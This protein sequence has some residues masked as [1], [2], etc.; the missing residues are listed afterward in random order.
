MKIYMMVDME[1]VSGICKNSQVDIG[2]TDYLAAR[3][4]M[5][6]D[7]NACIEGCFKGGAT[8]VVT[9]D[10]HGNGFNLIW[11]ELDPRAKYA[12][13][14]SGACRMPGLDGADGI[15]LLGYHAMAG[16]MHAV[17]EH[18]MSH[19][20]WQNFYING[21]RSGEI[22]I[23]AGIAGDS[24]VP[25]IMVSGDD[26]ACQE[27]QKLLPSVL[28]AQVKKGLSAEGAIL[29]SREESLKIIQDT[30]EK[31]VKGCRKIKPIKFKSPVKMRLEL[32]SRHTLPEKREGVKI[33]DGR[34]F[35]VSGRNVIDAL[36]KIIG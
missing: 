13:G 5:T 20:S 8:E 14:D 29:L 6:W 34:I 16:T 35:E 18:T 30:A 28:T 23:D 7:V 36:N 27:A 24:G 11:D 17:L 2:K 15:I 3:R 33:I 32:V 21:I 25:L 19:I 9:R 4:Y 22:A 1:G 26:K 10:T 31:A 12:M